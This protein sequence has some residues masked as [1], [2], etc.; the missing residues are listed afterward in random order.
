M[1]R[2]L[3]VFSALTASIVFGSQ[4]R[5]IGGVEVPAGM[6]PEVIAISMDGAQCTAS[7]VGPRVI[8]T[9]GH[10]A[11]TD[12][13]AKFQVDGERYTARMIRSP[14]YPGK[15]HDV[16]VGIIDR[17]VTGVAPFSLAAK[18]PEVGEKLTLFGFGC[19]AANGA[20]AG[21]GILRRGDASVETVT[22]FD[23]VSHGAAACF[24]DSGGPTLGADSTLA[25]IQSKGN[26]IDKTWSTSLTSDDSL[27]FLGEVS[28]AEKV[29]ICGLNADCTPG[30]IG[31]YGFEF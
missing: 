27:E 16:A 10:C 1:K 6:H 9:A 12:A 15:D 23:L 3:S 22:G 8:V 18:A 4:G 5:I 13:I 7:L 2:T 19:S 14:L 24:G 21:K 11:E 26:I 31:S 29:L 25:G 28:A 17:E 20:D 30:G